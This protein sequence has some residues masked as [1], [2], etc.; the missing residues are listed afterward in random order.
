MAS[1]I[2]AS[3]AS[4]NPQANSSFE[5]SAPLQRHGLIT[6]PKEIKLGSILKQNIL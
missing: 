2:D 6:I 5:V 4:R 1:T 3:G